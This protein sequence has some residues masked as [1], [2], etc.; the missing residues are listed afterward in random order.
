LVSNDIADLKSA[1][2][3]GATLAETARFLCRSGS[4]FDVAMKSQGA[5]PK[6]A[7]RRK[8]P[9]TC[10]TAPAEVEKPIS[11]ANLRSI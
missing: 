11:L 6:V 2:A 3:D 7:A 9:I 1:V 10:R 8:R 4:L 5:R